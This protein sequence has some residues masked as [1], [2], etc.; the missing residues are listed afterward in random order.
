MVRDEIRE[1]ISEEENQKNT[2][3]SQTSGKAYVSKAGKEG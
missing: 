3:K 2:D 1:K